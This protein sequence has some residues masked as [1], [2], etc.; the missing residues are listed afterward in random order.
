MTGLKNK[1]AI[2]TGG[3]AGIGLEMVRSLLAQGAEV[4]VIARDDGKL[5]A[6]RDAGAQAI[7]GDA[8]DAA[9]IT[10]EIDAVDPD[11]L[12]L[13]AGA[14]LAAKT[15]DRQNWDDFSA[16][17]N[18]DVKA[19]FIGIQA[20]LNRPLRPGSRV[21][22]TSSGAA[23]VMSLPAIRP[24]DLRMSGGYVGAKRMVWFMAH[25]ANAV[26][27]ERGLGILFQVLV[28]AQ[29]MAATEL[30]HAVAAAYAE[31]EGITIDEHILRRYG[32]HLAP[33]QV[34]RQVVELLDDPAY[35]TGV[36]YGIRAGVQLMPLD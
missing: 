3:S 8:T 33:E 10:R 15:L 35:R 36:A 9:L 6:A 32:S 22:V 28:P 12:I 19:T 16:V 30:G 17:W 5:A 11:I 34:G 25:Q 31:A 20:A 1:Q 2:V 23:M 21:L 13:N 18:T 29:L 26:S 14:R 24:E 7:A 27:R 4:T